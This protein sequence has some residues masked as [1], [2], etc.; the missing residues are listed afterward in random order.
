MR[1]YLGEYQPEYLGLGNEVNLLAT[2]DPAAFEQVV[3]LWNEALPVVRELAPETKVF[4]TFQYEWMLGRRDGWY[5]GAEVAADWSPL[6]RFA[7]A[8]VVG[9][10]TYPS[11][12]FDDPAALPP[13]YYTQ[14]SA[15]TDLPAIL[16]E[17]GWSADKALP[18][19]PGSEAEQVAF[20]DVL[21]AQAPA[22]GMEA[23]VW[24]FVF[25]DQ[26]QQQAFAQM[27]LRRD[28]GSPRPAWDRWLA[29]RA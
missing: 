10:T 27:D 2:A 4:V 9:F 20:I 19:L 11:L 22:A 21:A 8:D 7:G 24:T 28:D 18:L 23:M 1:A 29:I 13:G 3:S 15:H 14:I 26:V 6:G 25:G 5:G 16:T 12:V 17:V